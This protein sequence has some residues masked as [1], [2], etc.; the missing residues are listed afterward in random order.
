MQRGRSRALGGAAADAPA[1]ALRADAALHAAPVA[2]ALDGSGARQG[3]ACTSSRRRRP[4]RA[5]RPSRTAI[6]SRCRR[7][8]AARTRRAAARSRSRASA[9]PTRR[10]AATR[11][12][13]TRRAG[14]PA[15]SARSCS[16]VGL[17]SVEAGA[18][19]RTLGRPR[20]EA[21]VTPACRPL[22][23]PELRRA[24]RR[25]RLQEALPRDDM[26]VHVVGADL[27]R[28]ARLLAGPGGRDRQ[29]KGGS[30][31]QPVV[32][33]RPCRWR[34]LAI[35]HIRSSPRPP[36]VSSQYERTTNGL[37]PPSAR[38]ARSAGRPGRGGGLHADRL[39]EFLGCLDEVRLAAVRLLLV[40]LLDEERHVLLAVAKIDEVLEQDDFL[41]FGL[42][43]PALL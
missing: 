22:D 13:A 39:A 29:G 17:R 10:T 27:G 11:E 19:P 8:R 6:S 43:A 1:A 20:R 42:V 37:R 32:R 16:R 25:P 18:S 24:A 14:R 9:S 40:R 21:A 28:P 15:A 23:G 31:L 2:G 7:R 3:S 5:R 12:L 36:S 33:R 4:R 35:C 26:R 34:K 41:P 30:A 38:T